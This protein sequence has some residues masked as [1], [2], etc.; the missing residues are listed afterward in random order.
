MGRASRNEEGEKNAD[1]YGPF[2]LCTTLWITIGVVG[3]FVSKLHHIRSASKESWQ[4]DF[5]EASIACIVVYSYVALM[6]LVIW[7]MMK[8]KA[9]PAAFQDVLCVYG[10]SMFVPFLGAILCGVPNA[11]FQ[12]AVCLLCGFWSCFYLLANFWR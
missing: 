8:W 10:Y 12:W 2:W 1:L 11:M 5:K 9:V 3:N 4:Y 7:A 6:S